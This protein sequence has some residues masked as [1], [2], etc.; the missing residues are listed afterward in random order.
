MSGVK[1]AGKEEEAATSKRR[2]KNKNG[3]D[4][5]SNISFEK[6]S[7]DSTSKQHSRRARCHLLGESVPVPE[8]WN[9]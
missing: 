7:P 2:Q 9:I 1:Q 3:G 4:A 6:N 5:R 8:V